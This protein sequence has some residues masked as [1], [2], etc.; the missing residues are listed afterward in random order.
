EGQVLGTPLYMAPEQAAGRL[1]ELDSRTDI[2]GLGSILFAI[3]TGYAPH[4]KTQKASID[5]GLGAR[6]M[7]GIIANG[8]TPS[9]ID[10]N[11]DVDPALDAICRK[12]M[13]RRR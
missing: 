2:Y 9:A 3:V 13:A 8:V 4:E 11:P 10:A 6:G 12:A 5:S 7:I 1:D